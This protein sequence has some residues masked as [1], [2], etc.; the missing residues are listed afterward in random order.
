MSTTK[1]ILLCAAVVAVA[2]CAKEVETNAPIPL[3]E[4]RMDDNLAV[5]VRELETFVAAGGLRGVWGLDLTADGTLDDSC[6]ELE[7]ALRSRAKGLRLSE[8]DS[9]MVRSLTEALAEINAEQSELARMRLVEK[10]VD[11]INSNA[12]IRLAHLRA[13]ATPIL[14]E[15]AEMRANCRVVRLQDGETIADLC[16]GDEAVPEAERLSESE[17]AALKGGLSTRVGTF[18][19]KLD[20]ADRTFGSNF[21]AIPII[22]CPPRSLLGLYDPALTQQIVRA[23]N[24]LC[25][26]PGLERELEQLTAEHARG[27]LFWNNIKTEMSL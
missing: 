6:R 27:D 26:L 16:F 12:V 14:D 21:D 4:N 18:L 17:F 23:L 13:D 3:A 9:K 1:T 10:L 24:A 5:L 25:Q 15:L 19:G 20:E 22:C 2:G 8:G 11:D 7:T